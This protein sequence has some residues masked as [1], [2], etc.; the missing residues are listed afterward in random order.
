MDIVL[1]MEPAE[2]CS[3]ISTESLLGGELSGEADKKTKAF[4]PAK[5]PSFPSKHTYKWTEKPS[6]RETDPRKIREEA[7]KS[8]RQGEEALRRLNR[9]SKARKEKE[10][11]RAAQNDPGSKERHELW[12]KAMGD[13]IAGRSATQPG[14][15]DQDEDHS[16]I[17]NSDRRY[18]RKGVPRRKPDQT[19]SDTIHVDL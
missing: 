18:F 5:F 8:A 15:S 6:T 9:V 16:L 3:S 10:V 1:E 12:E 13:L 11:K 14:K 17:V 7:A 19:Q 4:I 2:K